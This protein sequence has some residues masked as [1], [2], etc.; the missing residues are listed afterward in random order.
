MR[1]VDPK[2]LPFDPDTSGGGEHM[3]LDEPVDDAP[4]PLLDRVS[5]VIRSTWRS[6]GLRA[7]RV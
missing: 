7:D 3:E 4:A 2:D 6:L 5:G 1:I